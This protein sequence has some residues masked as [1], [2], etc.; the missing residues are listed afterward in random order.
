M[1][2]SIVNEMTFFL[3]NQAG[4]LAKIAKSL[5]EAEVNV[6]GL[7]VSEGFGKSVVRIVVDDKKKAIEVLE[8][9]GIDDITVGKILSILMPSKS[10]M[11]SELSEVLSKSNMNIENIYVTESTQGDTMAYVSVVDVDEAMRIFE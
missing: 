2:A 3:S 11:L 1:V 4:E 5:A 9:L 6:K 10:G 8:G 7:L